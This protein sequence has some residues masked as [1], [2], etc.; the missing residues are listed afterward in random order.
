MKKVYEKERDKEADK[1]KFSIIDRDETNP[2]LVSTANHRYAGFVIGADWAN[3]RAEKVIAEKDARIGWIENE[4]DCYHK[5]LMQDEDKIIKLR[6][7]L[8]SRDAM[9]EKMKE[10]LTGISSGSIYFEG[11][12]GRT[13]KKTAQKVIAELEEWNKHK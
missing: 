11:P 2:V 6:D 13:P 12:R 9:I 8:A 5:Q 4:R 3:A 1:C 10:C 7:Q